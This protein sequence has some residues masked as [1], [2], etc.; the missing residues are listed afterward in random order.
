[1]KDLQPQLIEQAKKV[2]ITLEKVRKDE[3]LAREKEQVVEEEAEEINK[4]TQQI[5]LIADDAQ[6]D[7]DKVKPELDRAQEAVEHIDKKSLT[8]MKNYLNPPA[9]VGMVMEGVCI[10]LG[11]KYDWDTAKKLMI[12]LNGFINSLLKYPKDNIP[13]ERLNKLKKHINQ[14]VFFYYI[15]F[16]LFL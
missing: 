14:L 15:I 10:L 6:E 8:E 9:I 4:Q 7:F 16:I 1:M 12:D 11:K 13:E 2:K 5:K 3:K